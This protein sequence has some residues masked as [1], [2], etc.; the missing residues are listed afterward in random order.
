MTIEQDGLCAAIR[1]VLAAGPPVRLAIL[2]G[3]HARGTVRPDSDVDVAIVP[4][5]TDMPLAAELDLQAR[6]ERA[7]R[8]SVHLV[9]IDSASTT[10]RW[11]VARDGIAII[12]DPPQM[13]SRFLASA[14]LEHAE[15][16]TALAHGAERFRLRVAER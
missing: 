1:H 11:E 7:C 14:A 2:F 10:L 15:L 4:R 6:L 9:R 8:A 16:M 12:A 5:D 3:S 13:R